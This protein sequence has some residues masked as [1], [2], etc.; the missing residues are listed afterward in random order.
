MLAQ[1][2]GHG[3]AVEAPD[4]AEV[5]HHLA[6]DVGGEPPAEHHQ[7]GLRQDRP[8]GGTRELSTRPFYTEYTLTIKLTT[9]YLLV[10]NAKKK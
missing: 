8:D 2:L 5:L 3:D 1:L 7:V 9:E 10:S 6:A 4:G